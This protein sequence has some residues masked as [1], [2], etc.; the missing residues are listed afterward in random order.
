MKKKGSAKCK[1]QKAK[2][3]IEV[4]D[5]ICKKAANKENSSSDFAD[6]VSIEFC[7]GKTPVNTKKKQK[8]IIPA[9]EF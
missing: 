5:F 8:I 2:G 6:L 7:P 4:R 1:R 9:F 3:K